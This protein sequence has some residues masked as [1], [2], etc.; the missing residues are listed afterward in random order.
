MSN[1]NI[2]Q[3]EASSSKEGQHPEDFHAFISSGRTGRRNAIPD[4]LEDPNNRISTS[5]LAEQLQRLLTTGEEVYCRNLYRCFSYR[6]G[7]L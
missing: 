7:S 6:I 3:A 1:V 2:E 5:G 4:L